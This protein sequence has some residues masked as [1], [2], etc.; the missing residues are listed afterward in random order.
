MEEGDHQG[1]H[2]RDA[3]IRYAGTQVNT[4]V[5]LN[6]R[7]DADYA[8]PRGGF[9]PVKVTCVWDEGGVEKRDE[10]IATKA[11]ETCTIQCAAKPVM[12]SLV[13]EL[14]P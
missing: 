2:T 10:H 12:K 4:A 13:V 5:V 6:F 9:R 8:E 7:I 1:R 3:L 11:A 14:V